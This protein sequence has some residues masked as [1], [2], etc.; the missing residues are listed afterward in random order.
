MNN[1]GKV[2]IA[3]SATTNSTKNLRQYSKYELRLAFLQKSITD[4]FASIPRNG[5]KNAPFKPFFHISMGGHLC[6]HEIAFPGAYG[7]KIVQR[8]EDKVSQKAIHSVDAKK[9][10]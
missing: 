9:A 2:K 3:P 1:L 4:I 8:V 5:V 6:W 7:D 10:R